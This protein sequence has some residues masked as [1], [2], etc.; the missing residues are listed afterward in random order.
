MVEHLNAVGSTIDDLVAGVNHIRTR[1]SW[2]FLTAIPSRPVRSVRSGVG[3]RRAVRP[4]RRVRAARP[5]RDGDGP[6]RRDAGHRGFRT[7]VALKRMLPHVA[8]NDELVESFVREARLASYLATPT[9]R[10]PTTSARSTTPTSSR[11]SWCR[12]EPAPDP[13]P[14]RA[15]RRRDPAAARAQHPDQICDA[16]DY[17]HNLVRRARPAARHHPPRRLAGE[18][19][20]RRRAAS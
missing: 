3:D 13:A 11:W 9:S 14:L 1:R 12:A 7:A 20:R 6:S 8:A 5:R 18:H 2:L 17:A 10:R 15:D 19:H 16:L 4:V